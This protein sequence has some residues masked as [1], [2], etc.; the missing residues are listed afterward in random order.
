LYSCMVK[1][2]QLILTQW[3]TVVHSGD[4]VGSLFFENAMAFRSKPLWIHRVTVHCFLP[5]A[6]CA[7]RI[8]LI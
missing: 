5:Y 1:I 4:T 3:D 7:S 8:A 6:G 2:G